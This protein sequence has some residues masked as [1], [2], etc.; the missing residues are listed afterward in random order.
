[1]LR[2]FTTCDALV[3]ID[4]AAE[5]REHMLTFE[6]VA[7][8][9]TLLLAAYNGWAVTDDLRKNGV[10]SLAAGLYD[11]RRSTL[12][13]V[14]DPS[15]R[16]SRMGAS[17]HSGVP[18]TEGISDDKTTSI[19]S[20][21]EF[22]PQS[23]FSPSHGHA[24]LCRSIATNGTLNASVHGGSERPVTNESGLQLSSLDTRQYHAENLARHWR[25]MF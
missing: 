2:F 1:M 16:P 21:S 7:Q 25:E 12:T 4:E 20:H 11:D 6:R 15:R 22:Q 8:V 19:P 5:A 3:T 17:P 13:F 10:I 9:T 18:R 14:D 23:T 24:R